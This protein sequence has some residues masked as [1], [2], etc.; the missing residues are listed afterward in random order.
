VQQST[1]PQ[2]QALGVRVRWDGA[3]RG[4]VYLDLETMLVGHG[5]AFL[6][7][8]SLNLLQSQQRKRATKP[9]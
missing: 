1:L 2:R 6:S 7:I 4:L 3:E 8:R 9:I 5:F